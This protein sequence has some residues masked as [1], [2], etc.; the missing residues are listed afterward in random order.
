M[1]NRSW[2]LVILFAFLGACSNSNEVE[3]PIIEGTAYNLQ[4]AAA[5]GVLMRLIAR[6][7][8]GNELGEFEKV[9]TDEEGKFTFSDSNL[10]GPNL[11]VEADL[12]TGALAALA[13][14]GEATIVHPF[15][16][17][18]SQTLI[19]I[20]RTKDGFSLSELSSDNII[21]LSQA[22]KALSDDAVDLSD[23]DATRAYL[24]AQIGRDIADAVNATLSA[25]T[26]DGFDPAGNLESL[27]FSATPACGLAD[28]Y[29]LDSSDFT[30]DLSASGAVC[31][32]YSLLSENAFDL[33]FRLLIPTDTFVDN[34]QPEF[35]I[36]A[37]FTQL[38]DSR[39]IVIG[40]FL[41]NGGLSVT[42]KVYVPE[43]GDLVRY[44]D[45]VTN[46]SASPITYTHEVTGDLGSDL[47]T[48]LVVR[49]ENDKATIES[50]DRFAATF[51]TSLYN[52]T[53]GYVWQDDNGLPASTVQ[54]VGSG[55]PD[56]FRFVW[57]DVSLEPDE[58]KAFLYMGHLTIDRNI[59][60][61]TSKLRALADTPN[62][63]ELSS[64]EIGQIQNFAPSRGNVFGEA[65]SAVEGSTVTITNLTKDTSVET[66]AKKDWSF[67]TS[68]AVDA[69][70]QLRIEST[71]G[72]SKDIMVE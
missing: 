5:A 33:A 69:G 57:E 34:G 35:P 67:I 72:L 63:D 18:L 16:N 10:P 31:T 50:S 43:E 65:G 13:L 64:T 58:T 42:R 46:T 24:E 52:P 6:N 51:E 17:A 44:V 68:L 56:V 66:R 71:D 22:S 39:T 61:L 2:G 27:T 59:E 7:D 14:S 3:A 36:D 41:T 40:P 47:D 12:A 38:Q 53:V 54:F 4:G 37:A 62:M 55:A 29:E 1:Q 32:G 19:E 11:F 26:L 49:G 45:F 9:I 25:T 48:K 23:A 15:T 28:V 20:A 30:F 8:L 21:A 60:S 70:D